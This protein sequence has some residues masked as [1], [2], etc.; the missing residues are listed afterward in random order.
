MGSTQQAQQE[1]QEIQRLCRAHAAKLLPLG[2]HVPQERASQEWAYPMV[3]ELLMRPMRPSVS[4]AS[5]KLPLPSGPQRKPENHQAHRRRHHHGRKIQ[6]RQHPPHRRYR[7]L[8]HRRREPVH[9]LVVAGLVA[10]VVVVKV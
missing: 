4:H 2:A 6:L 5:G 3:A 7:R 8:R 9:Y 10:E 1:Q